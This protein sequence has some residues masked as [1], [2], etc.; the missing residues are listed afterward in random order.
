[1]IFLEGRWVLYEP[2]E[3]EVPFRCVHSAI[4]IRHRLSDVPGKLHSDSGTNQTRPE[5]R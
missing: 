5:R 3:M 2:G 4:E 1:V